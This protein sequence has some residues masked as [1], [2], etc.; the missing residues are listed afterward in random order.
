MRILSE[1]KVNEKI[2]LPHTGDTKYSRELFFKNTNKNLRQLLENRYSWMNNYIEENHVG[3]EVGAGT[4]IGKEFIKN[5]NFKLTDYC[6]NE[7]LDIKNIDALNTKFEDNSFDFVVSS[8]MIHHISSPIKFLEEMSR[9]IKPNGKLIIQEINCSYVTRLILALTNHEGYN[10]NI[11]NI[12]D[13]SIICNDPNDLWSA[14]T[15]IPNLLFD[16]A[17]KFHK[18][19]AF[20]KIDFRENDEFITFLNSGGVIAKVF[21][22]PLPKII[23]KAIH[24]FDKFISKLFPK[25]F[26]M[27]MKVVLSNTKLT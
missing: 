26:A 24:C 18:N 8:N 16:D 11:V 3:I 27:Q 22:I 4:G 15:A 7:W 2:K 12:F 20:F 6:E 13:R 23:L 19:V 14:N 10:Y 17:E 1:Y 5:K 21:Y 25:I 9:I